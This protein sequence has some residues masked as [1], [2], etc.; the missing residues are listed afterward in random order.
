ME[1]DNATNLDRKSGGS[2]TIALAPEL[3]AIRPLGKNIGNYSSLS[4]VRWGEGHPALRLGSD[5]DDGREH[6]LVLRNSG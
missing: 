6:L 3:G 4:Q 1:C 5:L 2:P